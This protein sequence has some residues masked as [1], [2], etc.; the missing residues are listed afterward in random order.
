MSNT[1]IDKVAKLS[2]FKIGTKVIVADRYATSDDA[3]NGY[4]CSTEDHLKLIGQTGKVVECDCDSLLIKFKSN[5]NGS[6]HGEDNR[7]WWIDWDYLELV[8]PKRL[9][10][11]DIVTEDMLPPSIVAGSTVRVSKSFI[12]NPVN[13]EFNKELI[14]R[15]G[16]VIDHCQY[17]WLVEFKKDYNGFQHNGHGLCKI[18]GK[19]K[20]CW[21]IKEEYLELVVKREFKVGDRVIVKPKYVCMRYTEGYEPIIIGLTGVVILEGDTYY[22][23]RIGDIAYRIHKKFLRLEK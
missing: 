19:V 6:L 12:N 17:G 9:T 15:K 7:C 13:V 23:V 1:V 5:V 18:P 22:N 20:S 3:V 2:D 14:G 21:F 11:S 4:A 10:V 8:T 16:I